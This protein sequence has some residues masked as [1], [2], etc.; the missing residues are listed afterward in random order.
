VWVNVNWMIQ[1]GLRS[2][3]L[4]EPAHRIRRSL[5]R[6]ARETGFWEYY[7][8]TELKGLGSP[9]FSWSAA[10]VLDLLG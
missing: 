6:L 9:D 10:L 1:Q 3:R 7:Y 4:V 5:L 2:Y 8:P